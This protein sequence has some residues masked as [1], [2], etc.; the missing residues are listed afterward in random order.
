MVPG[1]SLLEA[2]GRRISLN[3]P[4]VSNSIW[5]VVKIVFFFFLGTLD[6]RC[7]IIIG[8]QKGTIILTTTHMGGSTGVYRGIWGLG[9]RVKGARIQSPNNALV[10]VVLFIPSLIP[11]NNYRQQ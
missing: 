4:L 5:V 10:S 7:R 1:F 9:F 11:A 8:I 2:E 3:L 6:I